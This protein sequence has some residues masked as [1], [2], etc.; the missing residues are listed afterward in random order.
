MKL[1]ADF[2]DPPGTPLLKR[3]VLGFTRQILSLYLGLVV[4]GCWPA[5]AEGTLSEGVVQDVESFFKPLVDTSQ[6]QPELEP[7]TL[8]PL[9]AKV[10]KQGQKQGEQPGEVPVSNAPTKILTGKVQTLQQAI[11]S[12]RDVVNWYAWYL[13]ARE[14][15]GQTGGLR[16]SLGTPIKFYRSGKM[17]ALTFDTNC[18]ASVTGRRFPLPAN[19]SLDALILPV[20]S[21]QGPPAS[22]DEIYSR[23]RINSQ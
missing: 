13:S 12:E 18:I 20:R 2:R 10:Q 22:R 16:C 4:F 19:T 8:T 3:K 23:I 6:T 11:E 7:V 9:E 17:E 21:G 14:Y 15:I 1:A 5:L